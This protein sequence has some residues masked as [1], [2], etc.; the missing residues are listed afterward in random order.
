[1]RL[2]FDGYEFTNPFATS[3]TSAREETRTLIR[4][5]C[6]LL[7]GVGSITLLM[8]HTA[9]HTSADPLTRNLNLAFVGL[10]ALLAIT[11]VL[12]R[13][14]PDIMMLSYALLGVIVVTGALATTPELRP[15]AMFYMWPLLAAA[16]FGQRREVAFLFVVFVACYLGTLVLVFGDNPFLREW[17]IDIVAAMG[18]AT[19]LVFF[20]KD[21]IVRLIARLRSLADTD[22][23]TGIAN[24]AVFERALDE[25]L[26]GARED[27]GVCAVISLDLDRFKRVNDLYGHPAGDEALREAARIFEACLAER[28]L[29]ARVGGEEFAIVA[30]DMDLASAR[31]LAEEIR[32]A[33]ERDTQGGE[34]ALT[35]SI[36]VAGFPASGDT[37][38]SV[39]L[40]ADRALYAAKQSGRN[41][42]VADDE[43]AERLL[44]VAE[45]ERALQADAGAQTALRL[46]E[47]LDMH[48]YGEHHRSRE[49]GEMAGAIAEEMGVDAALVP[50]VRLAGVVRDVGMLGVPD[51]LLATAHVLTPEERELV[52]RHV[53]I[54]LEVLAACGIAELGEWVAAHHERQD[55]TGYPHGLA[56]DAIPL[57]ARIIA[58]AEAFESVTHGPG[59]P[60]MVALAELR[61]CS[62]SQFDEAVVEALA[63]VLATRG[64][65]QR[66]RAA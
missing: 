3:P 7:Y 9:G 17:V 14:P 33:I 23:L 65:A 53:Q 39:L 41:R 25:H 21:R 19:A 31:L 27:G 13:R 12:V 18:V 2:P 6:I 26:D 32:V 34:P 30:P 1:M 55:G 58:V 59:V 64:A 47:R 44:G 8:A 16:F 37:P 35:V 38:S 43:S 46:A 10:M 4:I 49:V 50:R 66:P 62:G 48:R 63:R 57:P 22:S 36:G 15:V 20:L 45:Q 60:A 42:V 61:E 28:G 11:M 52:E 54:G 5:V 24:R 56:G 40:A 51:E 29:L